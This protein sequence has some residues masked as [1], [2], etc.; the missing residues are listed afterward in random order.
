MKSMAF[1]IVASGLLAVAGAAQA[2]IVLPQGGIPL[3]VFVGPNAQDRQFIVGDKLFTVT[4]FVNGSQ[5]VILPQNITLTPVDFGLDG[6]G[7]QMSGAFFDDPNVPGSLQFQLNYTVEILNLPEFANFF[8]KDAILQFNGNTGPNSVATIAE[9]LT[10]ANNGLLVGNMQVQ[11][12]GALN[13]PNN[14]RKLQDQIFFANRKK[15]NV[16]KD[17]QFIAG[18]GGFA[19]ASFIRQTFSQVPTPGTLILTGIAGLV[20]LR[21]KR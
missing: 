6:I 19:E 5:Q 17:I 14:L 21:R 15:L 9:T 16:V 12:S 1:G 11:S 13:D 7:F 4:S 10:D 8:I 2:A 18:Q 20:G 3:G